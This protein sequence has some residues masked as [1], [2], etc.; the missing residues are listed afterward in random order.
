MNPVYLGQ[1]FKKTY[2]IYFN[3]FLQQLRIHEAKRLLRQTDLRIYEV[4]E[5]VG[6]GNRDYFVTKFEK[7]EGVT[8]S[9]YRH[10]LNKG[11]S[12]KGQLNET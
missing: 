5:R 7:M 6:F 1:L 3:D 2:G 11:G 9:V 10:R 12:P 4:S 8:P